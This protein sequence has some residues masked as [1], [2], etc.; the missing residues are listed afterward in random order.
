MALDVLGPLLG[1][2][3]I[4]AD[5]RGADLRN[6]DLLGIPADRVLLSDATDLSDS[7]DF[8]PPDRR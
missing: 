8:G 2:S 3:S 6:A 1:R 4:A 5:L 7:T